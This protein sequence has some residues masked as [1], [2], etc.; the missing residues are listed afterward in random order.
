MGM[1][2]Q[3]YSLNVDFEISQFW[4]LQYIK[5]LDGVKT[6]FSCKNVIYCQNTNTFYRFPNFKS[7]SL[8]IIFSPTCLYD[9]LNEI[10]ISQE[11]NVR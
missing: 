8:K 2:S 1:Q 6:V 3:K 9:I 4:N 11:R 7:L 5:L 10:V